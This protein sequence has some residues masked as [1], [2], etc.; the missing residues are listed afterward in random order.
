MD[1]RP[2]HTQNKKI[3]L[4]Q[5]F[6]PDIL[7]LDR[8]L[9][10]FPVRHH[11]PTCARL[12]RQLIRERQ[13]AAVLIEGPADFNDRLS[14]LHLPHQLP[15]ALYSYIH[16]KNGVRRGAFYPFCLYSPEWQALQTAQDLNIPSEFIDLPWECMALAEITSHRYSDS[17]FH[18]S[19]YVNQLCEKLG[20]DDFDTLWDTLFEIDATLSIETYLERAHHFCFHLRQS[21]EPIAQDAVTGD[22]RPLTVDEQ[23]EAFMVQQILSAYDRYSGQILV[24]TGG[25]HSYALFQEFGVRSS[26]FGVRKT[27]FGV[28]ENLELGASPGEM[29][30]ETPNSELRSR[31]VSEGETPNFDRSLDLAVVE[32]GIA[33]TPYSYERLDN[34]Q[35][36]ESGMPNPGFY[37]EVWHDRTGDRESKKGGDRMGDRRIDRQLA[38]SNRAGVASQLLKQVVQHLRKRN[39]GVSVADLIAVE[40]MARALADLRGHGEVWR[41]DLIDGITG[42]LVKEELNYGIP[43]PF[44]MAVYEVF[45]GQERGIL[46]EGTALPPLVVDLQQRL[47][48]ANLQ[49]QI[50]KRSIDLDL[51]KAEDLKKSQLLYQVSGLGIKGYRRLGGTDLVGREDLS[52]ISEQWEITWSPEFEANCIE[53]AIYGSTLIEAVGAR[54]LER[55]AQ[56]ERAADR[57]ALV[58]LDACLMGL[59]SLAQ[60]LYEQLQALIRQDADFRQVTTALG[61]LLYLYRYDEVLAHPRELEMKTLLLEAFQRGLWLLDGL[62]A[63][64]GD[65]IAVVKGIR[66][67]V[68]TFDRCGG[69]LGI[70]RNELVAVLQRVS[71]DTQQ[72][73]TLRGAVTGAIW[74]LGEMATAQVLS[75]LQYFAN[76]EQLGDFLTGLFALAR[77]VV[78]RHPE[79]IQSIDQVVMGYGDDTFLAALP[80]LRLA[81]S[82]F[83]PREKH[84]IAAILFDPTAEENKVPLPE[85]E[86]SIAT[87]AEVFA[88]ESKLFELAKRYGIRS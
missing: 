47:R 26:E 4:D 39:Q 36:Y 44:L 17:E 25:F 38:G 46:A 49:P 23:R 2:N 9:L 33:L 54:L 16:F 5:P 20:V 76:P 72:T 73:P 66:S 57:A 22:D 8:P 74:S 52:E 40:T 28:G 11:S 13:P 35:G 30:R 58:L 65:S 48:E 53:A 32:K 61:H 83:T 62:G 51:Y 12:L 77:E 78:Q 81:F 21:N 68:E 55:A 15:V 45:R 67:L 6:N 86:V 41:Q 29:S 64:S 43:H 79:L 69:M 60:P 18:Q 85:L 82:Y 84:S 70:D 10:F 34:L 50:H 1:K 31:S 80:A 19:A 7:N 59:D 37:H 88:F 24:V 87:A 63:M 56:L 3:G 14:E 75:N 42:A 27:G 71:A